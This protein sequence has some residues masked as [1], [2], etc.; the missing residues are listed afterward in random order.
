MFL[1]QAYVDHIFDNNLKEASKFDEI[2]KIETNLSERYKRCAWQQA[3]G[4]MQSF[5]S[6]ERVNK[7]ILKRNYNSR[8]CECHQ[9]R[10]I[11]NG[12]I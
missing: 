10:K 12:R 5:F 1:V 8:K 3:V 4:I 6:N 2:P 7:P 9:D 11:E